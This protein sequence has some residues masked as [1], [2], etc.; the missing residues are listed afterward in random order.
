MVKEVVRSSESLNLQGELKALDEYSCSLIQHLGFE[1]WFLVSAS[2]KYWSTLKRRDEIH[3]KALILCMVQCYHGCFNNEID[4]LDYNDRK[5]LPA[6]HTFSEWQFVYFDLMAANTLLG[7]TLNALP[8]CM[9]YDGHKALLYVLKW[10]VLGMVSNQMP[11]SVHYYI[12][13]Q[14]HQVLEYFL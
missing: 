3:I 10:N 9:I 6:L 11:K 14:Q 13:C 5:W 4:P 8:P 7:V 12:T 1:E 2:L